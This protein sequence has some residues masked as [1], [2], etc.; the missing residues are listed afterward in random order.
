MSAQSGQSS[1]GQAFTLTVPPE[2]ETRVTF[3]VEPHCACHLYHPARPHE[4]LQLDSDA[5]GIVSFHLRVPRDTRNLELR[6]DQTTPSGSTFLHT[7][8]VSAD[9]HYWHAA[10][11]PVGLPKGTLRP[12]LE[13]YPLGIS[14]QD[15]VERG[16][17]PQP[18]AD[19]SLKAH[20]RWRHL[21]AE[22]YTLVDPFRIAHEHVKF[23]AGRGNDDV[24]AP[25][26]PLPPPGPELQHA[27]KLLRRTF[28]RV[29]Q[30]ERSFYNANSSNWSGIFIQQ[31]INNFFLVQADWRVPRVAPAPNSILRSEAAM[32]T[33]AA[34]CAVGRS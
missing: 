19:R 1:Q 9:G 3:R 28:P 26:L 20:A 7:V 12:A 2:R 10:P 22:P 27:L 32:D 14:D 23:G 16:Y 11:E 21:V 8:V 33:S 25:T 29:R 15:L 31:P 18:R 24:M 4:R 34:V 30:W 17:P 13:A 5:Q 6:L